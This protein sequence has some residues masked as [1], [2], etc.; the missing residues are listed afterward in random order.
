MGRGPRAWVQAFRDFL[1]E[2]CNTKANPAHIRGA[3]RQ[4][5]LRGTP[6]VGNGGLVPDTSEAVVALYRDHVGEIY[7]Y[8]LRRLVC[9]HL[10]EDAASAVFLRLVERYPALKD[11]GRRD[12][13]HWL[14]GTA[15]NVIARHLRDRRRRREIAEELARQQ[16]HARGGGTDA[17]DRMDWPIL[18]GAIAR[19]G[20]RQQEILTL[21]YFQE[22][23]TRDIAAALGMKPVTVRVQLSRAVRRLRRELEVGLGERPEPA[24]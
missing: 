5:R 6:G 20:R 11:K 17:Y 4:A 7:A 15:S 18:Y 16:R 2:G 19:L 22:L 8:C 24:R 12:I 1:D 13:R 9:G 14:Y 10:A 3:G 21:R 23:E